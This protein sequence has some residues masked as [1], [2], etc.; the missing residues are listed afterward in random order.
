[1]PE[2]VTINISRPIGSVVLLGNYPDETDSDLSTGQ[3][4][5]LK[6]KTDSNPSG[7]SM[8]QA[9]NG[10][11]ISE[12]EAAKDLF[13]QS[14]K[15][16][17]MAADKLNRYYSEIIG[18][19]KEEIVKLSVEIAGRIIARKIKEGDYDISAIIQN[20]IESLPGGEGVAVHLNPDD[21]EHYQ[22][23]EKEI[24]A[25]LTGLKLISDPKVGRAECVVETP[26]GR[27]QSIIS[28]NLE[29]IEKAL[30]QAE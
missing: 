4:S 16:L 28:E 8:E 6:G 12:L 19:H 3:D 24:G 9:V 2:M 22:N 25:L 17:Q 30:I 18:G 11:L 5:H 15:A 13:L 14:G 29:R 27:I 26:K 7:K 20:A 10:Q 1:M 21:F 23:A